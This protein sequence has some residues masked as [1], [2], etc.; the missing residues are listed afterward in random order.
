MNIR[1]IQVLTL[2]LVLLLTGSIVLS[3]SGEIDYAQAKQPSSYWTSIAQNAWNYF[4]LGVGVS[5]ATGLPYANN[6]CP[7]YTD[8]DLGAYIQAIMAAE[9]TGVLSRTG[10]WGADDRINKVLTCLETRSRMANNLPY[11]WY[12]STTNQVWTDHV[13]EATATDTGKLLIALKNL[14]TYNPT[15]K[16]RID[17]LVYNTTNYELRKISVDILLGEYNTGI[18]NPNLYDYYVTKGFACF[19]PERYNTEANSMLDFIFSR[20]KIQY[21]GVTLPNAQIICDPMLMLMF[22]FQNNDPRI[23]N[24]SQDAYLAQETRYNTTGH[25]T[26]FSEGNTGVDGIYSFV[27]QWI[28]AADGRMW[29]CQYNDNNGL[30]VDVPISPIIFFKAAIGMRAL[31]ETPYTQQM[32]DYLTSQMPYPYAG[33]IQGVDETG[34]VLYSVNAGVGNALIIEAACY[35]IEQSSVTPTPTPSPVPTPFPTLTP[36]P[37]PSVTPSP[38]PTPTPSPTP[39]PNPSPTP[40]VTPTPS[41]T[42]TISPTPTPTAPPTST[43]TPTPTATPTPT[44]TPKPTATPSTTPTISPTPPSTLTVTPTQNPTAAPTPTVPELSVSIVLLFIFSTLLALAVL[45]KK[46]SR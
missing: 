43:P 35:A 31:Y 38:T 5:A 22:E 10:D 27:Y 44:S 16:N 8:W 15:L 13:G 28:V 23:V 36:T 2:G 7:Y 20:T 41:P 1:I 25:Y 4:S 21:N 40:T 33:Y 11:A 14:E 46:Q 32:V 19:W 34:R 24:L 6:D 26:A 18:R 39:T 9:Q 30:V 37:T 3:I 17:T 42:P 12:S 29:T 45:K